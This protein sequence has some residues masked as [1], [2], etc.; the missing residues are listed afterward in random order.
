[1]L[2]SALAQT[3]LIPTDSFSSYSTYWYDLY[4]W[5]TDHNGG[6]RMSSSQISVA[7]SVLTLTATPVTGEPDASSGGQSIPINYLSGTVFA[8]STFSVASGGGFDISAEFLAPTAYGTWPA[9]WLTAVEGWPPEVNVA[10]WKGTGDLSF[11]TFNTSS[12]VTALDVEYPSPESWHSVRAELRDENGADVSVAF[13]LDDSLITTQHAAEYV[14]A[15]LY[16]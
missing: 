12:E 10:E 9:F 7:T 5:G 13:Y 4:P 3:T 1:M 2:S 11:N 15:E 6:A 8:Q 14:G 16:L